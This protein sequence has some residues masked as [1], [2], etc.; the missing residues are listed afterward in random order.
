MGF[1]VMT[2]CVITVNIKVRSQSFSSD[3]SIVY[4]SMVTL[5][6]IYISLH[7][8]YMYIYQR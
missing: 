7:Y 6:Y 3:Q 8:I 4:G 5:H 2:A 1:V